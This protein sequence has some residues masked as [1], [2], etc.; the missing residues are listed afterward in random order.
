MAP[1][2][3]L[4]S[5]GAQQIS[6]MIA[7]ATNQSKTRWMIIDEAFIDDKFIG[8]NDLSRSRHGH[9]SETNCLPE[10]NQVVAIVCE[11]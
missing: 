10:Q 1:V 2:V 3:W 9:K 5:G 7:T 8:T 11:R 4:G 6:S